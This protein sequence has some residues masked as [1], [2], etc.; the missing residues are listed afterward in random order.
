[1][2]FDYS[3]L[4]GRIVEKFGTQYKFAVAMDLSERS[5][6]L[7]LNNKRDWRS[8]EIMLACEKL[9][10]KSNEIYSFFFKEKVQELEQ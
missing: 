9:E 5:L 1:M 7:K 4:Y 10:I 3:K 2:S 6:S 8:S